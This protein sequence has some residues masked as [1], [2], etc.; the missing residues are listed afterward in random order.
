MN[1]QL[2]ARLLKIDEA[3]REVTGVLAQEEPDRDGEIFDYASSVPYF[4]AWNADFEKVTGGLS[5][6]NVREMHD[7]RAVGKFTAMEYDDANKRIIVTG[8]IVDDQAWAKCAEGVYT[9][10]SIGGEYIRKTAEGKLTRYTAKP[11]E[12]SIVDYPCIPSATFE[13]VKANGAVE[14][15]KFLAKD[16]KTKRVDGEDLT[17]SAFAYV[18]DPEKT[19]TWKLPIKF[20]DE[21]KTKTHIRNA[22]ARFDQTEGIPEGEKAKVKAKIEAAAKEHGIDVGKTT[23]GALRKDLCTVADL[24][25]ILDQLNCVRQETNWEATYEQD[26]SPL[27]MQLKGAVNL[28]GRILQAMVAEEVTELTAGDEPNDFDKETLTMATQIAGL[29][30]QN[31]Q[32]AQLKETVEAAKAAFDNMLTVLA[33][34]GAPAQAAGPVATAQKSDADGELHKAADAR[35]A[36]LEKG[37]ADIGT[38]LEEMAKSIAAIAGQPMPPAA[39]ANGVAV[40]VAKAADAAGDTAAKKEDRVDSKDPDAAMKMIKI[41]HRNPQPLR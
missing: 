3:K 38:V 14:M 18:G 11:V 33:V 26:D 19:D 34:G 4:K 27:G 15:R 21:E 28:V 36:A 30:K 39:A 16:A 25:W 31:A 22:L 35:F 23:A 9:G 7:T 6:G 41:A 10:F 12:G 2:F 32:S 24:A 29:L 40:A 8:R 37:V 1:K 13:A 20:S 17:A 5:V